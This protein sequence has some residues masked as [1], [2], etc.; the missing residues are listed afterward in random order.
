LVSIV[1]P[2]GAGKSTLLHIIG[3]LDQP[4]SGEVLIDDQR[5]TQQSHKEIARF[6]NRH[7]GFIFQFHHL[8]PE[9]TALENICIPGY[10][11]QRRESEVQSEAKL[12]LEKLAM[13]ERMHHKPGQLSGGEQQRIAL[14]RALI[15]NLDH[16]NAEQVLQLILAFK[17]ELNMTT[18]IVTH[19]PGIARQTDYS[20]VMQDGLI[21]H[22]STAS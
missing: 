17:R 14:A 20:L 5:L 19:D 16:A 22:V 2:S 3:T 1:G 18:L 13:T 7:I 11:A 15:N 9:F 12:L 4:S 6:R 21:R 10:I 8:L